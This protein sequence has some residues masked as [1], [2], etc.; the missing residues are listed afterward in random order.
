V[1]LPSAHT[2]VEGFEVLRPLGAGG[3]GTVLLARDLRLG[4]QVAL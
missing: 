3:M 2:I 1:D 4:R